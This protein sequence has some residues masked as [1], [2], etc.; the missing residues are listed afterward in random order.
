M[1]NNPLNNI[2]NRRRIIINAEKKVR[3]KRNITAATAYLSRIV[4][5]RL[6]NRLCNNM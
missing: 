1:Y 3:C 2:N 5:N 6:A 4:K